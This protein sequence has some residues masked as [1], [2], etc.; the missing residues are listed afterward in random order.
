MVPA[1][2]S[3]VIL[4]GAATAIACGSGSDGGGG[5]GTVEPPPPVPPAAPTALSVTLSRDSLELDAWADTATI[6]ATVRDQ[7]G[8]VVSNAVLTWESLDTAAVTVNAGALRTVR[9]GNGRIRVTA[10]LGSA[11][12]G[13]R[14]AKVTVGRQRNAACIVPVQVQ[15]GPA[16]GVPAFGTNAI[17]L[18]AL[19]TQAWDGGRALPA[20][21]DG[22]G[23]VDVIRLEYSYPSSSPYGGTTRVFRNDGG[24]L[25]DATATV[26]SGTVVPDHARD[27]E[28]ADFTGDGATDV[29]VAQHGFD[30]PPFPGA[31]NLFF[32]RSGAQLVERA[33][34]VFNPY[35]TTSFSHASS[36]GDVDCDGDLDLVEL[37]LL[38]SAGNFLFLNNGSG[39]FTAAPA[40]AFPIT[41]PGQGT[42]Q[43]WQE[44]VLI[45]FDR[46]GDL[47]MFLGARSGSGWNEDVMLVNDGFGRFRTTTA[48]KLP[49]P[50]FTPNH[51]INNARAADFNGDGLQDM[52]M[53]EIPQPF[54]TSSAVRL[55]INRGNGSFTD[56]S[57][58]WGLPAMCTGELIEPLFLAD[59]NADGWTDVTLPSGC[60]ELGGP[61][62]L[63]NAGTRFTSF[64]FRNIQPWLEYSNAAPLDIDKDGRP[65]LFFGDRGKGNPAVLVRNP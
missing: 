63:I 53:F 52:I 28:I 40:T 2:R 41:V 16:A 3:F 51:A 65:D 10:T 35:S 49:A 46:D 13:V 14:E 36:A 47:D 23:D 8:A 18:D 60:T 44:V 4:S 54:S 24:T 31:A 21:Y 58:A 45:D 27:F 7:A 20:D 26:L 42:T 50:K 33:S 29:Y 12:P 57:A 62:L 11:T 64:P 22:D 15:R 43:R 25:V 32:T 5:T 55:W 59:Y 19:P 37:N 39:S 6:T 34:A 9:A 56:E 30:A 61:G 1:M 48:V 17:I 38:P